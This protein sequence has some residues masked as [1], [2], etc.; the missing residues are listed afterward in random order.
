MVNPASPTPFQRSTSQSY[1]TSS[2]T[3]LFIS[4][5]SHSLI[6][7]SLLVYINAST[8]FLLT[9]CLSVSPSRTG[10]WTARLLFADEIT[11]L[12]VYLPAGAAADRWGVKGVAILGHGVAAVG[13]IAYANAP[14]LGWLI[15]ARVLFALGAGSLVTTLSSMLSAVSASS[16]TSV[17][18]SS[19][20]CPARPVPDEETPLLQNGDGVDLAGAGASPASKRAGRLAGMMGFASGLGALLAV[21]GFLRL[22]PLLSHILS[23]TATPSPRTESLALI[24]TFYVVAACAFL[25][26]LLLAS[27]LPA[28]PSRAPRPDAERKSARDRV[29]ESVK[30]LFEGFKLAWEE[31]EVGLGYL[32]SFA[33]RAQAVIVTAYIPLLVTRYLASHDLCSTTSPSSPSTSSSCPKAYI[34]SSILTGTIQLLSLLLSP[35]I[36]YLSTCPLFLRSSPSSSSSSSRTPS[37]PLTLCLT[38]TLG[39]FALALFSHLPH[40]GDPRPPQSWVWISILG[41][42]IAQAAGVV[43]SLA[44]VTDGGVRLAERRLQE[45]EGEGGEGG[46]KEVAGRLGGSYALS[47]G[48]GILLVGSTAGW[49]FD[50]WWSGAPFALMAVLDGIVALAAGVVWLRG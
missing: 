9:Q 29:G 3:S 6:S 8:S 18:A 35:L 32:S 45:E 5:L 48:L 13:L 50:R 49:I 46:K 19:P 26:A 28:T 2:S 22:P 11:A 21:F 30:G 12:T 31:G 15:V 23:P 43:L 47:G 17:A 27:L 10:S 34:L 40:D 37:L 42:G 24:L 16:S 20:R 7:I 25:E 36:G 44:L 33:S 14:S 1:P 39:A 38:F 4:L 41:I